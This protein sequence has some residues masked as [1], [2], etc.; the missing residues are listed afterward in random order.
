MWAGAQLAP[1]REGGEGR[2]AGRLSVDE[3]DRK[4]REQPAKSVG[5]PA[6][7]A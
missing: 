1:R 2:R 5:E 3:T 7:A 6:S 4:L